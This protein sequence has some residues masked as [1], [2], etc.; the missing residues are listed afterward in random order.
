MEQQLQDQVARYQSL[1][2]DHE[3]LL[4]MMNE[5]EDI[6]ANLKTRLLAHGEEVSDDDEEEADADGEEYT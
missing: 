3:D 4:M 6:I 5:Q 2:T 1:E